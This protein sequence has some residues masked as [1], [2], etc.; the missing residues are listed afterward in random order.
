MTTKIAVSLPDELVAAA[1][2]AVAAGQAAS[3]SAFVAQTIIE[4]GRHAELADLL[5][6][7]ATEDGPPTEADRAWARQ[8][9]GLS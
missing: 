1:R 7:M 2:Q 4:H 3:V 5:A 8:A 6:D 9:L